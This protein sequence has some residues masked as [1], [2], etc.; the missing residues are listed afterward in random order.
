[1]VKK[2]DMQETCCSFINTILK[3]VKGNILINKQKIINFQILMNL[4]HLKSKALKLMVI[5]LCM[6]MVKCIILTI[7]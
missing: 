3:K 6:I 5:K 1:M 2:L 4:S 7:F